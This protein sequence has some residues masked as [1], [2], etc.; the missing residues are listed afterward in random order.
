[1]CHVTKKIQD[2]NKIIVLQQEDSFT[3]RELKYGGEWRIF[4]GPETS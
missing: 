4:S 2:S 3:N 1:M